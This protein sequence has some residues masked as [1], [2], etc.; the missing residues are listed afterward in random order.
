VF[1]TPVQVTDGPSSYDRS[2]GFRVNEKQSLA[3]FFGRVYPNPLNVKLTP[4]PSFPKGGESRFSDSIMISKGGGGYLN[5]S[6]MRTVR[7]PDNN[8]AH[9]LPPGLGKFPLFNVE[10]FKKGLPWQVTAQGGI[11]LPMYRK[12]LSVIVQS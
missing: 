5:I 3:A 6:F 1:T 8:K 4:E 12:Y 10:A 9:K 11:F 2:K 7:V